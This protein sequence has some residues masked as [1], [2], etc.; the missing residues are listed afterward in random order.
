MQAVQP[1]RVLVLEFRVCHLRMRLSS[2]ALLSGV[3]HA[4]TECHSSHRA[5]RMGYSEEAVRW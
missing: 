1:S 5:T 4:G 3:L 2:G